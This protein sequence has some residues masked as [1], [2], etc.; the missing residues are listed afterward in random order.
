MKATSMQQFIDQRQ[1]TDICA[2]AWAQAEGEL[3][4]PYNRFSLD[5]PVLFEIKNRLEEFFGVQDEI[6]GV[7]RIQDTL[8]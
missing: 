4:Q 8:R 6:E 3:G 1:F 2:K 5:V 7:C